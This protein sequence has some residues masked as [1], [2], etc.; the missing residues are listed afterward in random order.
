M[1]KFQC[2]AQCHV[3]LGLIIFI[4]ASLADYVS[5]RINTIGGLEECCSFY[6]IM[7]G[8][9][10]LQLLSISPPI[11]VSKRFYRI[12]MVSAS[13]KGFALQRIRSVSLSTL[14][15]ICVHIFYICWEP[16]RV[17]ISEF[18]L[19]HFMNWYN[20]HAFFTRR[21]LTARWVR[22]RWNKFQEKLMVERKLQVTYTLC[23][24]APS[25]RIYYTV[26]PTDTSLERGSRRCSHFLVKCGIEKGV[27]SECW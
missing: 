20:M 2:L 25:N 11:I 15:S 24:N 16:S 3:V 1:S 23:P 8:W 10:I 13:T 12:L 6:F 9:A 7:T 21:L 22:S 17:V 18:T 14:D 5:S 4:L 27:V 19:V 26:K